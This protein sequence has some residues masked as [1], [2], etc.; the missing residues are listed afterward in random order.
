MKMRIAYL[1]IICAITISAEVLGKTELDETRKVDK[2]EP[3]IG[4]DKD[5]S[6]HVRCRDEALRAEKDFLPPT[7]KSGDSPDRQKPILEPG[8]DTESLPVSKT[9]QTEC[10]CDCR[11]D[12]PGVWYIRMFINSLPSRGWFWAA[13]VL[14]FIFYL[15]KWVAEWLVVI[16]KLLI[17]WR[18]GGLP[19]SGPLRRRGTTEKM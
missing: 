19:E 3:P 17:W 11:Y 13:G 10:D 7:W 4:K 5:Q 16:T 1:V 2:T 18:G 12:E 6:G 14:L 15:P 8:L 9:T